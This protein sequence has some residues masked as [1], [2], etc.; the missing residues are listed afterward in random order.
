MDCSRVSYDLL[1][2]CPA[3]INQQGVA[4]DQRGCRRGQKH[5]GASDFSGFSDA[6]QGCDVLDG[7]SVK[8]RRGERRLRPWRVDKSWRYRVDIDVERTPFHGQALGQV[9]DAGLC[10]AIYRLGR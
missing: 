9:S 2:G 1:N 6:M 8:R 10:H 7:L 3:A 5:Y 4:G